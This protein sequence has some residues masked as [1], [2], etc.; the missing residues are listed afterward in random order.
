MRKPPWSSR[1]GTFDERDSEEL[2]AL[3]RKY[4][5]ALVRVLPLPSGRFALFDSA[6]TFRLIAEDGELGHEALSSLSAEWEAELRAQVQHVERLRE[7]GCAEPDVKRQA[8][9]LKRTPRTPPTAPLDPNWE[10]P[11]LDLEAV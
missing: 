9:D 6:G 11:V 2:T 4:S 7:I 10:A 3:S 8:R 1:T 5:S